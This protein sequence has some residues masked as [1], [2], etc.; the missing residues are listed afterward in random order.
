MQ[1]I[2]ELEQ[3]PDMER[4]FSLVQD[5]AVTRRQAGNRFSDTTRE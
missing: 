2:H 3:Y 4:I 5:L 1:L